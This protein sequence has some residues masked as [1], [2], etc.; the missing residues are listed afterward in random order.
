HTV[1]VTERGCRVLTL[2]EEEREALA[3]LAG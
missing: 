1:L 3:D 2:R